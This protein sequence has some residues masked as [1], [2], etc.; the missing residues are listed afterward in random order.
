MIEFD[1]RALL[2]GLAAGVPASILY[3]AGL[4]WSTRRALRARRPGRLLL[5]SFLLRAGLFLALAFWLARQAQAL[6]LLAG[7][8]AA[9]VLVRTLA[10]RGAR[11]RERRDPLATEGR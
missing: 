9:F 6:W 10:I 4:A 8:L 3:F 1:G 11:G 5:A 7:F 2:I